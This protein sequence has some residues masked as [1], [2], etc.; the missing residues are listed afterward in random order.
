MS[1]NGRRRA[2]G[3]SARFVA[4][5]IDS[6]GALMAAAVVAL[7]WA[8]VDARSYEDVWAL[9]VSLPGFS[10]DLRHIVNDLLMALFFFVV[11]LELKRERLFGSLRDTR[12]AA[13]PIAAAF[14]TMLGAALT[15]VAV[16]LIADGDLRGWAIPIATD[17]AFA[18]GALGLVGRR[19]PAELRTFLLTLAVVDD[20][21]TIVVIALFFGDSIDPLW[22]AGAAAVTATVALCAGRGIRTLRVYV[23][24]AGALWFALYRAGVHPTIAGVLLGFL[25]PGVA[26]AG[27]SRSPL[28]R[29]EQQLHPWSTYAVLP[30]FA[31]ANAGVPVSLDDLGGAL[32]GPI[33]LGIALGL[34]VGAPLA[35]IATS[36][37]LVRLT[38][39]RL[40]PGLDWSAVAGMAPLKGIGFT[41]AIFISV[42]AFEDERALQVQAKLAILVASL[43][44]GGIG[45]TALHVRHARLARAAR[46]EAAPAVAPPRGR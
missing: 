43:T 10:E 33:G 36:Y 6:A 18:V 31:L 15:Y 3:G 28:E 21:A 35:G 32:T 40:Q 38:P 27:E 37:A 12:A 14:G 19:A 24:L 2:T 42:L 9:E 25:T 41:V 7:V 46:H 45:V 20:L 29:C 16:N 8:N 39:A 13:V 11:A 1:H 26:R 5:E 17:I 34:V 22:L 23:P 30:I 44:S 4:L